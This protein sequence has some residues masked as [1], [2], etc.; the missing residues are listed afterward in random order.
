MKRLLLIFTALFSCVLAFTQFA[1]TYRGTQQVNQVTG[2]E[3]GT[4]AFGDYDNDG[5]MDM[6]VMGSDSL[7]EPRTEL[8]KNTGTAMVY[9]PTYLDNLAS[10]SADWGDFDA[11]GDLDLLLT[12]YN[13]NYYSIT[14]VFRNDGNDNFSFYIDLPG[15]SGGQAAWCDFNNDGF[16]DVVQSGSYFTDVYQN[17]YGDFYYTPAFDIFSVDAAALDCGDYDKDGDMD[18]IVTGATSYDPNTFEPLNPE[19]KIFNNTGNFN[20]TPVTTSLPAVCSGSVKWGDYD[21]DGDLDLLIAGKNSQHAAITKVFRNDNGT[22]VDINAGLQGILEG[23]ATW[24]DLNNDGK[25]DI[26]LTGGTSIDGNGYVQGDT[27]QILYNSGNDIF[28]N[29]GLSLYGSRFSK[30]ALADLD[31]DHAMDYVVLGYDPDE[32]YPY[33]DLYINGT[34]L[35]NTVP[36]A[37]TGLTS[38]ISGNAVTLKWNRANDAETP[39]NGLSYNVR[40]S[41]FPAGQGIVPAHA[42]VSTGFRRIVA[43]GNTS[44]DTSYTFN[45]MPGGTVYWSVQAVDNNFE[46]GPFSGNATFILPPLPPFLM[47]PA[48]SNFFV[49]A[50]PPFQW[51]ASVG[52]ASYRFQL[53]DTIS[54]TNLIVDTANLTL[55]SFTLSQDLV[56]H[57]KYYWRTK[58]ANVTGTS[59]WSEVWTFIPDI[60]IETDAQINVC[61]GDSTQLSSVVQGGNPPFSYL[62]TPSLGL[63]DTTVANPT[64]FPTASGPYAVRVTDSKGWIASDTLDVVVRPLPVVTGGPDVSIWPGSYSVITATTTGGTPPFVFSWNPSSSLQGATS[65][66]PIASPS[67]FTEYTVNVTDSFGCSALSPDTVLAD[68][69]TITELNPGITGFI[70]AAMNL[71][72][73]DN[74]NDLDL[75]VSGETT[76][77]NYATKLYRN[78]NA[79]FN[80]VNAGFDQYNSTP[81]LWADFDNDGDL[82]VFS[83]YYNTT[84][85]TTFHTIYTNNN[86]TFTNQN[87]TL[88]LLIRSDAKTFDFDNDG[89]LDIMACGTIG[90]T[91]KDTIILFVNENGA[92]S[93]IDAGMIGIRNGKIAPCD[94]DNDGD[95]DVAVAGTVDDGMYGIP[96]LQLYRNDNGTFCEILFDKTEVMSPA[97]EWADINY[98]GYDDLLVSGYYLSGFYYHITRLYTNFQTYLQQGSSNTI[99]VAYGSFGTGDFDNDG[100]NDAVV[101][102]MKKIDNST[103]K[104]A[105]QMYRNEAAGIFMN[106]NISLMGMQ[107]SCTVVGDYDNDGDLDIF[108]AGKDSLNNPSLKIYKIDH[109]LVNKKPDAPT[110]LNAQVN[111]NQVILSWNRSSDY[112]TPG[113]QLKYNVRIGTTNGGSEITSAMSDASTGFVR[114]PAQTNVAEDTTYRIELLPAG[115]YYWAVQAVDNGLKGSDFASGTFVVNA[116]EAPVLISPAHLANQV[117]AVTNFSW[118]A[119]TAALQYRIQITDDPLFTNVYIDTTLGNLTAFTNISRLTLSTNYYWRVKAIASGNQS[120]WSAVG[121]F[122]TKPQ[123]E[124]LNLTL[125]NASHNTVRAS[126]FDND[127]DKDLAYTAVLNTSTGL[128]T[129]ILKNDGGSFT[130]LTNTLNGVQ[131]T[132]NLDWGDYDRDGYTDLLLSGADANGWPFTEVYKNNGNGSFTDIDAGLLPVKLGSA[133]WGDADADGDLDILIT[134]TSY[135]SGSSQ[136]ELIN[137]IYK[138]NNGSF[139]LFDPGIPPVVHGASIFFD[140]NNDGLNDIAV[141][142]NYYDSIIDDSYPIFKIFRNQAGVYTDIN[143]SNLIGMTYASIDFGD[144]NHDGYTDIAALGSVGSTTRLI[145]YTNN[146][147][148]GFTPQIFTHFTTDINEVRWGDYDNNGKPDLLVPMVRYGRNYLYAFKNTGNGFVLKNVDLLASR[149]GSYTWFDYD[150]DHDL[151]L[152]VCGLIA[153]NTTK[154]QIYRNN[155]PVPNQPPAAPVNLHA[156]FQGS[157]LVV[158]WNPASD[159]ETPSAG[160]TYNLAIGL[161]YNTA[162]VLNPMSALSTGYRRIVNMGNCA[163]G[164][165]AVIKGLNPATTYYL[166]IQSVDNSFEGSLFSAF[167]PVTVPDIPYSDCNIQV[168]PNPSNGNIWITVN[169]EQ[170]KEY[171]INAYDYTGKCVFSKVMEIQGHTST[172]LILSGLSKGIYLIRLNDRVN[173]TSVKIVIE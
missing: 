36:A 99:D 61:T 21:N 42:N 77:M 81:T 6:L 8:Y 119:V 2:M 165:S 20:F 85:F 159:N 10:S 71:G 146:S 66:S 110:G 100:D 53:S 68:V 34:T 173:T 164:T 17:F 75:L 88:P 37:P 15:I 131:N 32:T 19:I 52:A 96:L 105:A 171:D 94:F 51:Q 83:S 134:G 140:Y 137:Y 9:V 124:S 130:K 16:L 143:D 86:G 168:Y 35:A 115:T 78:D 33:T 74:D 22:W 121:R 93:V 49:A 89:D 125:D 23:N 31:G 62:W 128:E 44:Q 133:T 152:A 45:Y 148:S 65:G 50:R 132:Y 41:S 73:Y 97:L 142:G 129:V 118:S 169:A 102:G 70:K 153:S 90:G 67:V 150:N 1:P 82:D 166:A 113:I 46:G 167:S 104:P 18:F 117:E 156:N 103:A 107:N 127:N 56:R 172:P 25:L 144:F 160:L 112:E 57:K 79:T 63:S 3:D 27:T 60:S 158:S 138:N 39:K 80:E 154:T 108:M 111:Q 122:R 54:F 69:M 40:I 123:F 72:D 24:G 64:L 145:I 7:W 155:N 141:I 28:V 151:D 58:A 13:S 26:I 12:G 55:T 162:A 157:D 47:L 43:Y 116:L 147:G 106:P 109:A 170:K 101:S 87:L 139:T 91:Q 14:S 98:D 136:S 29:S 149:W 38:Q 126:D 92:F 30:A 84:Q 76:S 114:N 135:T 11:D 5:D 95:M 59:A 48:D 161:S 4:I 120:G 163:G